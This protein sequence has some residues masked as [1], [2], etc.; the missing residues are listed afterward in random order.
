MKILSNIVVTL[1]KNVGNVVNLEAE[2]DVVM[3]LYVI[4]EIF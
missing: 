3:Q 1:I 4:F 2:V